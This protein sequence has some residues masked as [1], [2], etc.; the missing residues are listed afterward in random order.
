MVSTQ[1]LTTLTQSVKASVSRLQAYDACPLYFRRRYIDK[2]PGYVTP[3]MQAGRD[4]H[5]LSQDFLEGKPLGPVDTDLAEAF[6]ALKSALQDP[7]GVEKALFA[8]WDDHDLHVTF[9]GRLDWYQ[10]QGD[11]VRIIDLKSGFGIIGTKDI[12]LDLQARV[13]AWLAFH[14]FPWVTKV[15]FEQAQ[16][17]YHGRMLG[18]DFSRADAETFFVT[19][20][21]PKVRRMALDT[22]FAPNPMCDRCPPGA[23]LTA[24]DPYRQVRVQVKDGG[25]FDVS[26][27]PITTDTEF[28]SAAFG[29]LLAGRIGAALK[30]RMDAFTD[31]NGPRAVTTD[32]AYG[33]WL[34]PERVCSN[35]EAAVAIFEANGVPLQEVMRLDL[36]RAKKY[37]DGRKAIPEL[38]ALM[39]EV[40]ATRHGLRKVRLEPSPASDGATV[41][42]PSP[43]ALPSSAPEPGS[44]T[45]APAPSLTTGA[46]ADN[47]LASTPL[48]PPFATE[49][50][51][52]LPPASPSNDWTIA[53]VTLRLRQ[54][55]GRSRARK[56]ALYLS[57]LAGVYADRWPLVKSIFPEATI[58]AELQ[59]GQ[60]QALVEWS[61]S[62]SFDR[63][64]TLIEGSL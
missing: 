37:L 57:A 9:E 62:A 27:D 16:L 29:W 46:R 36:T 42:I 30:Q 4:V 55:A 21:Q 32:E 48:A 33:P 54:A 64:S 40:P 41:A 47:P 14:E 19:E 22:E 38:A 5:A 23:H 50:G 13:Y 58:L 15:R 52:N 18:T 51:D 7:T 17:R 59:P 60:A 53:S 10:L 63:E 61:Q 8:E 25:H 12:A 49:A 2:L 34:S 3:A 26:F 56:T 24:L 45:S 6:E 31:A 43:P 11:T 39:V 35:I 44:T 20:L 28:Q 1:A